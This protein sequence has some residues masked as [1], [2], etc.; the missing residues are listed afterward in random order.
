[1]QNDCV[2]SKEEL[3]KIYFSLCKEIQRKRGNLEL[4]TSPFLLSIL[5]AEKL[6]L[7]RL[8]IKV[9]KLINNLNN[10]DNIK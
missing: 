9:L 5:S 10:A 2:F 3:K 8:K 1:M 4:V 7:E 6:E